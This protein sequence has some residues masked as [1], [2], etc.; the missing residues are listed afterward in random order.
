LQ[1]LT[2][3][4]S[5][6]IRQQSAVEASRLVPKHWAELP[7]AQKPAI[8]EQLL[9]TTL[10][11]ETTLVRHSA[12][13]VVSAIAK[14]DL[15]DGEWADLPGV[16]AKAS[17]SPQV[18][19][20]EVGVYILFTL[21]EAAGDGFTNKLP[22]LFALFSKT[23]QDPE[24][25]EVRINTMM[26]LSRVAMLIEPDEDPKSLEAFQQA[27][28]AMVSVLKTAVDEGDEDRTMQAFEVFQTL[29]GCESALLAKH[30]KDLVQFMIDLAVETNLAEESRSQALS[31]L[32]QCV[33]YRR[34]KIQGIKDMGE[35]LT[36]KSMQI[37]AEMSEDDDE[38]DITP[39]RS[40]L[41]LL[42]LL[43][44]SL[45]PRQVIVPLLKAL[46]E[47]VNS[48]NPSYRK[49]GILALGMSVE[50]AP[51]FIATQLADIMPVVLKLLHDPEIK[52][53]QAA[54][55]GV[56]RLADDLAEDM[57]KAH[58][59]L[60][61]ALL[62][63][64]E[65]ALIET[66]NEADQKTG[67][68]MV[69][70]TCTALEALIDGMEPETIEAY[71]PS[72]VPNLGRLFS[73]PDYN[74]KAAA[75]GAMGAIAGS[76]EEA[77]LPYFEP[78]MKALSQYVSIKDSQDELVL[79]AAVCDT[80]GRMA[81]AVGGSAFQPYVQPLMQA[82]EEALHLDHPRLRETSYILW[83]TMAKL[84]KE[85]F[86]PFLDGVVKGLYESLEQEESDLE[87]ELGEEA[88][89]L[90]GKEVV[91]EGKKIKVTVATD[92]DEIEDVDPMED[93]DDDDWDD[94]NTVTA[95]ALEKE[96]SVEVMGDIIAHTGQKYIP[97][98]EKTIE[99]VTALV[100]HSY[101]GV[102]K[103]AI[104]TLWRAYASL[105]ELM[106]AHS[107]EKWQPGIP[108]KVQPSEELVK[109]GEVVATAT[110]QVW[111]DDVDRY[112]NISSYILLKSP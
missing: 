101:E 72:L 13:R 26:A 95:V 104:G 42:D 84:Y 103:A 75:A 22:D 59:D 20:R 18:R 48:D 93:D 6:Q 85:E 112:L 68:E 108:L 29:L 36:T 28:P 66:K 49:A 4:D 37:V 73:H 16:L 24:S 67:L 71:A 109:L 106:E 110:M 3:H 34:M 107:G 96:I 70:A 94:L 98:L 5:P 54:L 82:S 63:N 77:F 45:P 86:T 105:W 56:T 79:R 99:I 74:V 57:N 61:P 62:K 46:P 1:I 21:L 43:A 55:H 32:M 39:A 33:K 78:T 111:G 100:D 92:D 90:I 27:F 41:G 7:D 15:E 50:G 9:Q 52:V 97:Y 2:S 80:M 17:T 8:R 47:Y 51:D 23:I 76:A 65:S 64:L 35:Q 19:H 83:S 58:A 31:F 11:E 102:R 14:I 38:D 25:Q 87:V 44:G 88:S 60:V 91:I 12:A 89:D 81:T 30:F 53:R 69:I 40:A 10:N